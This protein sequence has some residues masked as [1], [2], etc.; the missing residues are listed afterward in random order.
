MNIFNNDFNDFILYLNQYVVEYFST[1][2][3]AIMR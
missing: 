1:K 3:A 2:D